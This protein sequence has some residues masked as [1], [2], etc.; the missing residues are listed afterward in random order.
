MDKHKFS[1]TFLSRRCPSRPA[2]PPPAPPLLRHGRT[3][4]HGARRR[5]SRT[6]AHRRSSHTHTQITSR[7]AAFALG[8][9]AQTPLPLRPSLCGQASCESPMA[10][11]AAAAP[12]PQAATPPIRVA[13]ASRPGASSMFFCVDVRCITGLTHTHIDNMHEQ[14]TPSYLFMCTSMCIYTDV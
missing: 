12:A 6:H 5:P 13:L 9:S 2:V 4:T 1:A 8:L 11:A 14:I 3:D 7:S 10:A